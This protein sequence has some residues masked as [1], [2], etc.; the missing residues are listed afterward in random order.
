M[1][2]F[3]SYGTKFFS[4]LILSG[5]ALNSVG[6]STALAMEST[7]PT[8]ALTQICTNSTCSEIRNSA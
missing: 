8:G 3:N 7:P 1:R 4:I 6:V 2:S 5:T